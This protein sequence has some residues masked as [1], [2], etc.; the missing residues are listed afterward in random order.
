MPEE[1]R[2][3]LRFPDFDVDWKK[4]KFGTH[5]SFKPTNSF[6]RDKLN[7]AD[8]IVKNIHYGDIHTEFDLLFDVS[9]EK[10]PYINDD[11]NIENIDDENYVKNGDLVVAD[12]SEDYADIGKTI[13]IINTNGELILAGLHTFLARKED[14][15]VAEGFFAF[16]LTTYKARLEIMRIAQG[17]KVLGLSKNRLGEIP[18]YIPESDEQQKIAS[19]LKAVDK[20][21]KLLKE[22]KEH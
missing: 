9:K 20:R 21:I 2:P 19:F 5:Y 18:I 10:V 14:D 8:G 22:K 7:Y 12:A 15:N 6:S 3:T 13:E 17:T 11:I 16:L 1:L 4:S